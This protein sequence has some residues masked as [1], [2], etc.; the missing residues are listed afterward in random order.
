MIDRPCCCVGN[1]PSTGS[2]GTFSV[3]IG[4][5]WVINGS[6]NGDGAAPAKWRVALQKRWIEDDG[7]EMDRSYT[8]C[9]SHKQL[10][11]SY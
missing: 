6:R 7:A 2:I 4:D 9:A 1:I 3:A 8:F 11:E 5:I 10:L